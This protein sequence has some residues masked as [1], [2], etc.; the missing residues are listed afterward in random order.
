MGPDEEEGYGDKGLGEWAG[1]A[2]EELIDT[3]VLAM[4]EPPNFWIVCEDC[5]KPIPVWHECD[6]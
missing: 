3:V 4:S 5:G 2:P 1:E 6:K